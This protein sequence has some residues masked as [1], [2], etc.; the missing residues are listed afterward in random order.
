ME[1]KITYRLDDTKHHHILDFANI[2]VVF[3]E[4]DGE[5]IGSKG[6]IRFRLYYKK[7]IE[8]LELVQAD[9]FVIYPDAID[10]ENG[11]QMKKEFLDRIKKLKEEDE[12][13]REAKQQDAVSEQPQEGNVQEEQQES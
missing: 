9:E 13:K 10:W 5:D 12:A 11:G 3:D 4:R 6:G 1:S 8:P 7:S 2:Q